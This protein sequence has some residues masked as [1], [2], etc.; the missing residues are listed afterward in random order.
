MLIIILVTVLILIKYYTK[1]TLIKK[2]ANYSISRGAF[3]YQKKVFL[4]V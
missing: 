4:G 2:I 1:Y 3:S